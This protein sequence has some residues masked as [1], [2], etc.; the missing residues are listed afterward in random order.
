MQNCYIFKALQLIIN[1]FR[2]HTYAF[3]AHCVKTIFT[4]TLKGTWQINTEMLAAMLLIFFTLINI[5]AHQTVG[6]ETVSREAGAHEV[7]RY[8]F[9]ELGAAAIVNIT[10]HVL[11]AL[12]ATL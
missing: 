11:P 3:L 8:A 7:T 5:L 4:P 1:S 2:V 9:T 10:R 6:H 12:L